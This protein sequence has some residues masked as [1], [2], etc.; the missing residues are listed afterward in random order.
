[1]LSE[2][3]RALEQSTRFDYK[4]IM[5]YNSLLGESKDR[6]LYR[7]LSGDLVWAGGNADPEL[8]G[9]S[10]LDIERV[11]VLY[12]KQHV[13]PPKNPP[14][15]RSSDANALE[16]T[17]P[18]ELATT[19]TPVPIYSPRPANDSSASQMPADTQ[20]AKRWFS[21][22]TPEEALQ[23]QPDVFRLWPKC[24]GV[25]VVTYCFEDENTYNHLNLVFLEG[26]AK[27]TRAVTESS[28]G[29][30]PDSACFGELG[31]PCLCSSAGVNEVT[32]HIRISLDHRFRSTFGYLD[33][34]V[35]K[36]NANMPRHFLEVGV[37]AEYTLEFMSLMIA[38]RLGEIHVFQEG[39]II[40]LSVHAD[41]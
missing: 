33:P 17:F 3:A 31:S 37:A 1:M 4:S 41:F 30:A 11:A 18:G 32:V 13:N 9:L 23:M 19:T 22:P 20:V 5:I 38:H 21:L 34:S 26:V 39:L 36:I 10:Q 12:P 2:K 27:W 7:T 16:A 35:P 29:F 15:K 14:G 24:G 28:L 25:S 40:I 6:P 8:A